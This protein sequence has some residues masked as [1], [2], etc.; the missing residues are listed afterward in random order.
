MAPVRS[1]TSVVMRRW[2]MSSSATLAPQYPIASRWLISPRSGQWRDGSLAIVLDVFERKIA[3]WVMN[4]RREAV[5][6]KNARPLALAHRRPA[7]CFVRT[8]RGRKSH[9]SERSRAA[10]SV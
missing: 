10:G 5:L 1:I 6:G 3:G 8:D 2:R 7:Y 4:A 9:L